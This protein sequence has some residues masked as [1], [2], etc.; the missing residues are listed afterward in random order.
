MWTALPP[1]AMVAAAS[2]WTWTRRGYESAR[3]QILMRSGSRRRTGHRC[4]TSC[5]TGHLRR[6]GHRPWA[7]HGCG[8]RF[9]AAGIDTALGD[10]HVLGDFGDFLAGLKFRH[11]RR[12]IHL[13]MAGGISL[14]HAKLKA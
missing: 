9:F 11:H 7:R 3:A 14:G 6:T 8:L 5:G 10:L 1:L 4:R 2:P 13:L 12:A